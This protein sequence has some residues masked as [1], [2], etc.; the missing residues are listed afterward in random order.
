MHYEGKSWVG[1]YNE[2]EVE[3]FNMTIKGSKDVSISILSIFKKKYCF[4]S[5]LEKS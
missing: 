2:E 5:F 1:E 3:K 4:H